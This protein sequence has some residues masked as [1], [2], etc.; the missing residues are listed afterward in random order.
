VDEGS[1]PLAERLIEP[2]GFTTC[3]CRTSV[4]SSLWLKT[5]DDLPDIVFGDHKLLLHLHW[6]R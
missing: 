2:S 6:F 1:H 5:L 4:R 3:N